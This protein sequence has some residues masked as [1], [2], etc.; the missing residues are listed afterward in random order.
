MTQNIDTK[1]SANNELSAVAESECRFKGN[2]SFCQLSFRMYDTQGTE[3]QL[4]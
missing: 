3:Q 1:N 4:H 2:S